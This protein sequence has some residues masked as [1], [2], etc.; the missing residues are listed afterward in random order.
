MSNA[1]R[2]NSCRF[3]G[4]Q[5]R[6]KKAKA[7]GKSD[8]HIIP[9]WLIDHL[10]VR[11]LTI[12]PTVTDVASGRIVD[13]R[14]HAVSGFV[15]GTVCGAC[16]NGWMSR[17]ESDYSVG[18]AGGYTAGAVGESFVLFIATLLGIPFEQLALSVVVKSTVHHAE[19]NLSEEEQAQFVGKAVQESGVADVTNFL[20][21][22]LEA[23]KHLRWQR[24]TGNSC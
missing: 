19:F 18:V 3:C 5:L 2:Q 22:V 14:K 10:G 6:S 12:T 15:A 1:F 16:N 20:R 23:R 24:I 9:N 4:C 7:G 17:L 13:L 8:E 21:N 11:D